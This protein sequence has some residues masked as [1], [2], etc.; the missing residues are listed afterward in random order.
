MKTATDLLATLTP[1]ALGSL[2]HAVACGAYDVGPD[3]VAYT[4]AGDDWVTAEVAEQ[5]VAAADAAPANTFTLVDDGVEHEIRAVD[6][7]DAREQAEEWAS[8]GDYDLSDGPVWVDVRILDA[9]GDVVDAVTVQID[10]PEPD[11][12]HTDGHDWQG[13]KGPNG[14]GG[15]VIYTDRC[16]HCGMLRTTNTWATRPDNGTQGHRVVTYEASEIGDDE[17]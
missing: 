5:I 16:P 10:Q 1:A 15:G 4:L 12:T 8:E 3:G 6:L 13:H 17:D 9:D 7:D 2:R 11:C 14:H